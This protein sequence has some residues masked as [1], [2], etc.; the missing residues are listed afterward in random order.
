MEDM[1]SPG[2]A[3]Y[4]GGCND[5]IRGTS[6]ALL[7]DKACIGNEQNKPGAS[8]ASQGQVGVI[9]PMSRAAKSGCYLGGAQYQDLPVIKNEGKSDYAAQAEV[10]PSTFS[11]QA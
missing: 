4:G 10:A 5:I 8:V 3:V 1:A 9:T 11:W 6:S 2:G 7:K